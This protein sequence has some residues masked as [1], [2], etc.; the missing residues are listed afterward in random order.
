MG[1]CSVLIFIAETM[2]DEDRIIWQADY[3]SQA[4]YVYPPKSKERAVCLSANLAGALL[5]QKIK[6]PGRR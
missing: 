1:R 5:Q 6:Q 4:A 3:C 2:V